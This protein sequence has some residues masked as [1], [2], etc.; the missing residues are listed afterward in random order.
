L[1]LDGGYD[2]VDGALQLQ[3]ALVVGGLERLHLVKVR[4]RVRVGVGVR[5]R[6]RVRVLEHLHL[7]P[8]DGHLG[9]DLAVLARAPRHQRPG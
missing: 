9:V 3:E 6:V 2:L 7:R 8:D 5:V 1:I 4:V